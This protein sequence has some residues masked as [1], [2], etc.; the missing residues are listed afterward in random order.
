MER[1][2][3][4]PG[5]L[6]ARYIKALATCG[7][8]R[9]A[10]AAYARQRDDWPENH[11]SAISGLDVGDVTGGTTTVDF[12][13]EDGIQQIGV[14][15]QLPMHQAAP[16][17]PLLTQT[18]APRVVFFGESKAAKMTAGQYRRDAGLKVKK[19]GAITVLTKQL[20]ED[21]SFAAESS[22]AESILTAAADVRDQAFL[23]RL[24]TGD[25][26]TPASVTSTATPIAFSGGTLADLDDALAQAVRQLVDAG[27]NLRAA[28]WVMPSWGAAMLALA[29]RSD[30][31][32]AYPG[33]GAFGGQIAGIPLLTSANAE[34]EID[35]DGVFDV[36]LL[37][38]S[39]ITYV[40]EPPSLSRS[41]QAMVELDSAATGASDTPVAASAN[42]VSCFQADLISVLGVLRFNWMV[43]RPGMVQVISGVTSIL[44]S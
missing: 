36:V 27:S 44:E 26:N 13:V 17:T 1:N 40:S 24:N 43:R 23:D 7:G 37:D 12:D 5:M 42:I 39:Q 14:V 32:L 6:A 11:K 15:P 3:F 2:T 34:V 20:V 9:K 10:L 4:S 30:G 18:G 38:A 16:M 33:V 25:A 8:D 22:V 21:P 19:L 41:D 35:S 31:A 29:R 28:R